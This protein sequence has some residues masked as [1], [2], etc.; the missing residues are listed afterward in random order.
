[1]KN[2]E[3]PCPWIILASLIQEANPSD[4]DVYNNIKRER[5]FIHAAT[6]RSIGVT[7]VNQ[8]LP[9]TRKVQGWH[10]QLFIERYKL[11][12]NEEACSRF[13][14]VV[15]ATQVTPGAATVMLQMLADSLETH[16]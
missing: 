5:V 1:M 12:H 9:N 10:T 8:V 2:V 6:P 11:D 4:Y 15:S 3:V 7:I 13:D 16:S 14:T